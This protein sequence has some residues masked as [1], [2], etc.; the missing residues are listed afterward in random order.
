MTSR[1]VRT[2]VAVGWLADQGITSGT[3]AGVFSPAAKVTRGQMAAFLWRSAGSPAF[4]GNHGFGDVP[5]GS[6]YEVAVGWLADQGITSGTSAGVFSP[7]AKVTRGQMA[8]FLWRSSCSVQTV[9]T[10]ALPEATPG[11]LARSCVTCSAAHNRPE[12]GQMGRGVGRHCH[13]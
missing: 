6:Y 3:S 11:L 7:A 9:E 5:A 13:P 4:A 12:A 10:A 2:T 8:A 1:Q